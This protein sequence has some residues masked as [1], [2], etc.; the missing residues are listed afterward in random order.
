MSKVTRLA[1]S[2]CLFA[3][4][5]APV[6]A[7]P[8]KP[9]HAVKLGTGIYRGHR[10]TYEIINGRQITEGDI[11]LDHVTERV[12][13]GIGDGATLAY[14]QYLW[15][16][17]GSVYQI[18]YIIDPASGD[19][20]N[21]N[22]AVAQYNSIFAGLIQ[23]VP[24][25]TETDYIDFFLDPNDQSGQGNSYIGRVGGEQQ[26]WGSGI[27]NVPTLLHEMGHA[28]G[29]WHEQSRPDRA[30]YVTVNYGNIIS[31]LRSNFDQIFDDMQTPT[32]YDWASLMHYGAWTFTRNGG[33]TLESIPVGMPLSNIAG[34]SAGDIDAIKRLYGF[35]PTAITVTSNPPGLQV[36]VDGS[37]VA[38]PQTFNWTLNSTH[39]L[40]VASAAQSLNGLAYT[41]G[42]WNDNGTASHT[43]TVLPGN[44]ELAS[45]AASPAV[46]VYSA[47]FIQLVPYV[48]AVSPA[49]SGT[50]T[51]TPA[52]Q[53]YSGVSGSYYVARQ[54]VTLT[55]TPNAGQNFYEYT[56]SPYW[57]PGGLS[58]NPKTFNV[59][60][61]GTTISTVAYF[62]S[63]PVYTVGETP[64]LN[65]MYVNVDTSYWPAPKSFSSTYD[66]GWTTGSSHSI[67]VDASQW[68]YTLNSRYDFQSW[69]DG[70]AETHNITLP[71]VNTTYTA[72]LAPSYYLSDYV[73]Q[74]CAGS[75]TVTPGSP[76]NDGFYPG[77][78]SVTFTE[79]PNAGWLFTGWLFDLSGNNS[80]QSLTLNDEAIVA[81]DYNTLATPISVTGTTPAAAVAG[82]A[83][84]TLTING[85]GFTSSSLVFFNNTFRTST[86]VSPT[87]LTIP[88]TA[89]DLAVPGGMQVFVENFP[90]GAACAAYSAVPFF[91]AHGPLIT[92]TPLSVAFPA[93]LVGTTS[94]VK[95]VSIKNNGSTAVNV[96]SVA[97]SG[98]FTVTHNCPSTLSVG[99]SCTANVKFAPTVSGAIT[100]NLTISDSSPDSPQVVTLTGT[101]NT[102][103]SLSPASLSFG[104]VAVGHTSAA[105]T[106]TLTNNQSVALNFSF[107]AS[108]NYT[109]VGSGTAPC[110]TT[111]NAKAKCT[112]SVTFKPTANGNINGAVTVTHNA[113][114]SP[115]EVTLTGTGMG[116]SASPLTFNPATVT[117]ANQL[118]GTSSA[119]K[120]V[121]VTNASAASLSI[122]SIA[123]SGNYTA[124]GSGAK[125]CGG[126]LAAS[127]KCTLSVTF[128]PSINGTIKGAVVI[129]DTA[130]VSQQV[131]NVSGA[132][133]LPI[134]FVP[135][136]LTFAAQTVGTISVTQTVTLTNNQSASVNLTSIAGSGDFTAVAGGASPCGASVA[137]HAS[138]TFVVTFKPTVVGTI[139]GVATVTHSAANSPQMVTATGT[140]K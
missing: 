45:P 77:G 123:A 109:A 136:T 24:M 97:T 99:A 23:W 94:A 82:N 1:L 133:V 28:T 101:G 57:L 13:P 4:I 6:N 114:N 65:N 134:S 62:S 54:Q 106:V 48:M 90:S 20:D 47:N 84:L 85:S 64:S 104:S 116:G 138:C 79:T 40:S 78:T 38:T 118:V 91:V 130:T 8:T 122:S 17:V 83:G 137:G 27:A 10:V 41:Y 33:A 35:A 5:T 95:A 103:V 68:P 2:L 32:P 115:Q 92:P 112:M 131:L 9:N 56:N 69:S 25:T 60:D 52:P 126:T 127:A 108:R 51:P 12:V 49:N 87:Q 72:T 15:P 74:D 71:A 88:L 110:G 53:T 89:T 128:T 55:A 125:P 61:D 46:T 59:M 22:A 7:A 58:S 31:V 50:V 98:N 75:L 14:G 120:T 26:I 16:K 66:F 73:N 34:Y 43:I 132:G 105:K 113:A 3:P 63:T 29:M 111:L 42:R 19:V 81:A 30:S 124:V 140:G 117:F 93:Q 129:T 139:Q 102:P 100:G 121:T 37:A 39:T 18:P 96:S 107:A 119:A 67:S 36:M 11:A 135:A 21:I 86:F 44:G 76:T 80:S 70:G